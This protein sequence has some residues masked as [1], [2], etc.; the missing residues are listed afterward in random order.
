MTPVNEATAYELVGGDAGLRQLVRFFYEEM[1]RR[2][3]AKGIRDMHP[4]S[5]A[6]S[7]EKLYWFLS[8]WT[9][10]PQL[11]WEKRGHPMLRARHL[12]FAIGPNEAEQWIA[13]F[14]VALTRHLDLNLEWKQALDVRAQLERDLMNALERVALHMINQP[15]GQ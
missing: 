9:G 10:G 15:K 13:C 5:L 7:E 2:P 12:P 8:G 14:R 4:E 6:E 11:F 1:D 3:E